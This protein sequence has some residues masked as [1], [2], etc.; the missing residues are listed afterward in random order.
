MNVVYVQG[1]HEFSVAYL[2]QDPNME[3]EAPRLEFSRRNYIFLCPTCVRNAY[4]SSF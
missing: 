4:L 3:L 1:D 2:V